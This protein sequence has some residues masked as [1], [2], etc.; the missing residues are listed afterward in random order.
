MN[1][2]DFS[3]STRYVADVKTVQYFVKDLIMSP[4]CVLISST[5]T[6]NPK[7]QQTEG[8]IS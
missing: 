7:K 2:Q 4:V 6:W 3:F 1:V 5:A 8:M